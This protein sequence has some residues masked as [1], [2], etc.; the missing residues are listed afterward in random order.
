MP[1]GLRLASLAITVLLGA[2]SLVA[3]T[4][5][6]S[7]L[8]PI[9]TVQG[10]AAVAAISGQPADPPEPPSQAACPIQ[11]E[12]DGQRYWD[13]GANSIDVHA[14]TVSDADLQAVGHA[15]RA[16]V[17][18][19]FRDDTVYRIRGVAAADA[20]AMHDGRPGGIAIF[21]RDANRFPDAL[22]GF[23]AAPLPNA[24]LCARPA[25]PGRS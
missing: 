19:G 11:V 12:F 9:Q 8:A 3:C 21:V 1:P 18:R 7:C 17:G 6:G 23:L 24:S 5:V 10:A 13:T 16:T 4:D 14:W 2:P 15:T 20:I 25:S 22:C